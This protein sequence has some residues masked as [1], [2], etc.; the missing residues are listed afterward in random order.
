MN[1]TV[2]RDNG[3]PECSDKPI[4][5]TI[6]PSAACH[7]CVPNRYTDFCPRNCDVFRKHKVCKYM[8][9][10][11]APKRHTYFTVEDADHCT[12]A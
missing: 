1:C 6:L 9:T 8:N 4:D 5:R 2:C 10:M 7:N 12:D 11:V 3:V